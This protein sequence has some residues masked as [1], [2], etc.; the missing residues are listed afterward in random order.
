M[1]LSHLRTTVEHYD[2]VVHAFC[3]MTTHYHVV[4]HSKRVDLS[5]GVQRLNGCYA[6]M[7]N[8]RHVRFGHLFADRFTSKVIEGERYLRDAGQYVVENPVRVG[9]C[10]SAE[11]WPWA[12]SRYEPG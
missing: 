7:F 10:D 11:A 2:W 1:F 3:L 5:R 9:I 4:L 12:R 6:Q 8:E